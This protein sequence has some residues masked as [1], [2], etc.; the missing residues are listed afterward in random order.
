MNKKCSIL[1]VSIM[2]VAIIAALSILT[3]CSI[4]LEPAVTFLG[5]FIVCLIALIAMLL[6]FPQIPMI[7]PDMMAG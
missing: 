5:P 1:V 4:Y 6:A 2:L 7:L 3:G